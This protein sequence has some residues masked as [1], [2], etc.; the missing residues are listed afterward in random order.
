M[1]IKEFIKKS[2][3][4]INNLY[5]EFELWYQYKSSS[6]T[7]FIKVAA[8]NLLQDKKFSDL[9]F[10]LV[11][12]FNDANFDSELCIIDNDALIELDQPETV[13]EAAAIKT[14][15]EG[16]F[17]IQDSINLSAVNETKGILSGGVVLSPKNEIK[18][19]FNGEVFQGPPFSDLVNDER[20]FAM[21]A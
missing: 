5:P 12:E 8:D 20:R 13:I 3:N 21:A 4:K 14:G 6:E 11:D 1:T 2:L 17:E 19:S 15:Y 10:E 9:Y 7:H 16:F 18:I